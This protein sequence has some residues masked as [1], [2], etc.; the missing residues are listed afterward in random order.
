MPGFTPERIDQWLENY[1]AEDLGLPSHT[2]TP[3]PDDPGGNIISTPVQEE[4]GPNIVA[5][6]RSA[7]EF[8]ALA[9]DPA[10]GGVINEKGEQE[11]RIG[12]G[13]EQDG[14]LP[15][16]IVRDPSGGAEFIDADGQAWDVKGF[17]S[18]FPAKTGGFDVEKD[19]AKV[20]REL[21]SGHNVIID[22][23]NLSEADLAALR[24]EIERRGISERVV[25]WP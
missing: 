9:A 24:I 2:G 12:L 23:E 8:E 21:A 13:A 20:E 19:V 25:Y 10:R 4:A 17:R 15:G 1:P 5:T 6:E 22:T 18:D 16:P 3:V 11:R 14:L 7:E